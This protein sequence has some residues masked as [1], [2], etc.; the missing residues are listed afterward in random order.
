MKK[1][2]T[3]DKLSTT[4]CIL[5]NCRKKLKQRIVEN[6]PTAEHCYECSR[7]IRNLPTRKKLKKQNAS[8]R[9]NM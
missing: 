6:K 8:R 1:S 9:E 5:P 7:K 4:I 3:F 2:Y